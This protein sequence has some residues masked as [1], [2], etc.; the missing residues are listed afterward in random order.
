MSE[1]PAQLPIDLR[2]QLS[3]GIG[4]L[5]EGTRKVL[6]VVREATAFEPQDHV[7]APNIQAVKRL[8][9]TG[10]LQEI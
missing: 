6:A 5:G 1:V 2:H 4:T 7:I 9:A 8:V 10:R 3:K